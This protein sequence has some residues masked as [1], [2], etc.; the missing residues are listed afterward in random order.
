MKSSTPSLVASRTPDPLRTSATLPSQR[1]ASQR[2]RHRH[3]RVRCDFPPSRHPFGRPSAI[4]SLI[5]RPEFAIVVVRR[6]RPE[7]LA[8]AGHMRCPYTGAEAPNVVCSP[9]RLELCMARSRSHGPIPAVERDLLG[10]RGDSL[11]SRLPVLRA[12][13]EQQR[14]F[15]RKQLAQLDGNGRT[16]EWP[17]PAGSSDPRSRETALALREVDALV[18][19]GARRALADIE[20]ASARMRTGCYGDCRSCGGAHPSSYSGRSPRPRFAWR[21]NCGPNAAT[22]NEARVH[23]VREPGRAR[24]SR[25]P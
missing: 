3:G 23:P 13:L 18:S 4:Y 15:R 17:A 8:K 9:S 11:A 6:E 25:G 12:A 2:R 24:G 14:R 16:Y 20:L 10:R 1:P 22:V 19:A 7:R 5:S 21:A